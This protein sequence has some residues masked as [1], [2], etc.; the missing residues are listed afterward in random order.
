MILKK[1]INLTCLLLLV[2]ALII[3]TSAYASTSTTQSNSKTSFFQSFSVSTV[4]TYFNS[5]KGTVDYQNYSNNNGDNQYGTN[6]SWWDSLVNWWCNDDGGSTSGGTNDECTDNK[7]SWGNDD[8]CVDSAEIW[9]RW[10][11]N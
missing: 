8:G 9:K 11:C 1:F 2:S 5:G 7:G 6:E 10:Y 3:P 4:L